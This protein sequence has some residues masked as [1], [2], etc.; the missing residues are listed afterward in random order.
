MA[1]KHYNLNLFH[2]FA[3]LFE[4]KFFFK[5]SENQNSTQYDNYFSEEDFIFNFQDQQINAYEKFKE[6]YSSL[7]DD[8]SQN[9]NLQ[10]QTMDY[11][12]T[13]LNLNNFSLNIE[14]LESEDFSTEG[15]GK[16][17]K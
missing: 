1:S 6:S 9:M 14:L 13:I 8:F 4:G 17:F 12:F 2:E 5:I 11:L 15:F 16:Y 10:K 7:F 3:N